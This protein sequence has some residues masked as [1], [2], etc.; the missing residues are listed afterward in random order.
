MKLPVQSAPVQRGLSRALEHNAVTQSCNWFECAGKV[1]ACAGA[2]LSGV[3]TAAC[4][5]CL[6]SA[7]DSCKSC[8]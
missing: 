6:G 1:A 3:G 7:Y 4:I 5:A 8:F 2:C